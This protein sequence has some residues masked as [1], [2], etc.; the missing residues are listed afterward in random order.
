MGEVIVRIAGREIHGLVKTFGERRTGE[1]VAMIDSSDALSI[2][3]VNGDA[4]VELGAQ[5]GQ[6]VEIED[7]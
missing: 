2:C 1:L 3:I 6:I 5:P 4:S 7:A